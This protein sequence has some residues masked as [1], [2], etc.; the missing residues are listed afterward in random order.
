MIKIS[1]HTIRL[2]TGGFLLLLS[3]GCFKDRVTQS[4][5][6]V[7]PVYT[8]K[9]TVLGSI[10]GNP[11]QSIGSIGRLYVKDKYIYLNE[12]DKGI[13]IIDNSDPTRPSQVAFLSIPGNQEIAVK[14]NILYADMYRDLLAIDISNPLNIHVTGTAHNVFSDRYDGIDGYSMVNNGV[15]VDSNLILTGYIKKD[16]TIGS[17]APQDVFPGGG[18]VYYSPV[19]YAN[20]S[21][22]SPGTGNGIAGSMAKMVLTADHLYTISEPHTLGIVNATNAASPTL[23]GT[24]SAGFDLETVFPFNDKLFLGSQEGMYIYDISNPDKPTPAATFTH[25]HACDPVITDGNYA[26]ITLHTGTVC[27]GISNELDVVNVQN[28]QQTSQVKIYP[29]TKPGGLSKDNNLLFICDGD[30]GVKLYDASDPA[31]LQFIS[32]IGQTTA[33]DVIATNGHLLVTASSGLYQYD[34][35]NIHDIRLVSTISLNNK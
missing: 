21:S 17:G 23:T 12:P 4:Y 13:H 26:Y 20:S 31:N 35:S 5:T 27:G 25:G 22:S 33:T 6:I 14:G 3:S 34:Y 19:A 32:Q 1:S 18:I 11:A 28:L 15:V 16:T 29:M 24:M 9:T 10:K 7:R 30:E 2:F 8:T